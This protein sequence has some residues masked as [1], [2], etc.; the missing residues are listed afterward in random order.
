MVLEKCSS[1][2]WMEQR[3]LELCILLFLREYKNSMISLPAEL[4]NHSQPAKAVIFSQKNNFS[5]FLCRK[6]AR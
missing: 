3:V 4:L 6:E 2:K 5:T 1:D